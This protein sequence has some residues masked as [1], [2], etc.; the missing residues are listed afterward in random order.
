MD[1]VI[2]SRSSTL[3]NLS[4]FLGV[5]REKRYTRSPVMASKAHAV[6]PPSKAWYDP[7]NLAKAFSSRQTQSSSPFGVVK[8]GLPLVRSHGIRSSMVMMTFFLWI[9]S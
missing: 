3:P 7:Q 1:C 4:R 6:R 9:A 8:H 5:M 2:G